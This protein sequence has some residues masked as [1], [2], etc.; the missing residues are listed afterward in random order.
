MVKAGLDMCLPL[1]MMIITDQNLTLL[2]SI[3]I[4]NC[5]TYQGYRTDESLV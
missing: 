5:V 1:E 2:S 3:T 4:R